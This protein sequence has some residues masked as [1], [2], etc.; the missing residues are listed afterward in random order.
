[1]HGRR[2]NVQPQAQHE[3]LAHMRVRQRT[4]EFKE[5]YAARAGIEGTLSQGVRGFEVRQSRYRGLAKTHL[6]HI[7]SA[8]AIN[9]ARLV[10]WLSNLD[11]EQTR[12]SSF[13][14]LAPLAPTPS[15][16]PVF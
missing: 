14:R 5:E 2:L 12:L 7:I 3:A 6:Q 9:L 13:A 8:V 4:A 15:L 16:L 11:P 1:M 10:A